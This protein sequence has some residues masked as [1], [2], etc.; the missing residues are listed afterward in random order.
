M[1]RT[2]EFVVD[3]RAPRA[4][5]WERMLQPAT[6]EQWTSVFCEGSRY[7]GS[8]ERGAKI[9]FLA[10]SG[11]GMTS[12]IAE[13]R[14]H[15]YVSIRHLGEIAHGVEDFTS[16]RVRSWAPA[17]ENYSFA[18]VPGGTELCV[19]VEVTPEFETWMR[20]TYPRAL[21][22]LKALCET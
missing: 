6:Y 15:E 8:W 21:A 4:T 7:E 1:N 14:L 20:D 17:Y 5:V 13:S 10:P 18:E 11:D 2:L 12:E 16:E 19:T 22:H 3:I 9:R